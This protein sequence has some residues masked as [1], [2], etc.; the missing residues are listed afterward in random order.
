[1]YVPQDNSWPPTNTGATLEAG[2]ENGKTTLQT[3]LGITFDPLTVT[4]DPNGQD[5]E[6]RQYAAI[7]GGLSELAETENPD[8]GNPDTDPLDTVIALINDASDG[9]VDGQRDGSAVTI[10]GSATTLRNDLTAEDVTQATTN[11]TSNPDGYRRT[12]ALLSLKPPSVRFV[13]LFL[14]AR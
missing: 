14:N 10:E 2:V 11:F 8:A 5:L 4:P 6:S 13:N 1:L 7:L 12:P 9:Q 3:A